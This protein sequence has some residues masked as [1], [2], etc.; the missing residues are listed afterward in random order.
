MPVHD[1]TR[2]DAG[3]F[4]DMHTVW[5]GWLRTALNDGL[6]PEGYYALAEQ[7]AGRPITDVLTLHSSAAPSPPLSLPLPPATGGTVL[8]EA[9]P[10]VRRRHTVEPAAL[11]R[12]RSL[13]IRHVSGHRLV[14]L[15][16]IVSPA[17]KDRAGHVEDF[18]AK[19][20]SALD[21]GVHV[22]VVD[23]FPPGSHDE[24]GMHGTILQRLEQSDEPY[25]LPAD[26]PLTLASYAA[27][28]QIEIFLEHRAVGA[29]L[30]DMPL[31]LR[32]DR[33]VS[34][35]LETTYQAAYRGVPAFWRTVLEV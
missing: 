4:H 27:G 3:I 5:T 23:L 30:P 32:P 7:H 8:A 26:E 12:R 22:L 25:D 19:V 10:Q 28:P 35:P 24:H 13:A 21:A 29:V 31:F 14:A 11:A 9:P 17:N 34:V 2:V 1:W 20:V 6:L 33:Y 16:E 18:A 15:L